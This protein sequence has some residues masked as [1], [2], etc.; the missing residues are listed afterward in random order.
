MPDMCRKFGGG[1]RFTV[2][3]AQTLTDVMRIYADYY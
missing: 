2:G 3:L 1:A